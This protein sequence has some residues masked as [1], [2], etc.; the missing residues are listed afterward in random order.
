MQ[1]GRLLDDPKFFWEV[2]QLQIR[3]LDPSYLS[4]LRQF[5]EN[6]PLKVNRPWLWPVMVNGIEYGIPCTSHDTAAGQIGYLRYANNPCGLYLRYMVPVP[7]KALLPPRPLSPELAQELKF[8]EE[9]RKY[10]EAET[11]ILHRLAGN[12]QM[13]R[14]FIM[15][16]CDYAELESVY[17]DWQ[18]GFDAGLFSCPEKEDSTM[19]VSKNGKVYYTKEQYEAAR[20]NSNALEYAKSQGYELVR[21]GAYYTMK[22]H[23]S[24][25]FTPQGTWFWNSRGVH[26]TALEFQIYYEGKTLTEA[27]LTL[28]GEQE[29]SRPPERPQPAPAAPAVTPPEPDKTDLWMPKRSENF[30]ALFYYLCAER[31]LD[32]DVV[33]EMIRQNRLYQSTFKTTNGKFLNNAVFVYKDPDG[34]T[35]GAYQRGVKDYEGQPPF[36]RDAA[37]SDKRWGWMLEGK[38]TPTQVAVFEGAI[39]AASDASLEA[40]RNGSNWQNI[41]RISLE[42]LSYQPLQNYLSAHPNVRSVTL[43]LDGDEP[44]R[45][46]AA[47]IAQKLRAQ[48]YTVEDRVPPFGKDWNE[49]LKDVRSMEA[50]AQEMARPEPVPVPEA[51]DV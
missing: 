4:F 18:P 20:Y 47:E 23:D 13:D 30:K 28:A 50:E 27:V 45:R 10:I 36:K 15:R 48:G 25:V 2:I 6:I 22:E 5:E 24:M 8:F 31:G 49:V 1:K 41:D 51:P 7:P 39:D 19:P 37:G 43:M 38:G 40:I 32:G 17:F 34:K 46:A 14:F 9:N 11:Q 26:G 35:V 16:S 44:G 3:F 21:Q 42:G 29:L 33:K 12:K